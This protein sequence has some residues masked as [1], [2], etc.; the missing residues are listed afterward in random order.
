MKECPDLDALVGVEEALDWHAESAMRHIL[1]CEECLAEIRQVERLHVVLDQEIAPTPG[2][3]DRVVAALPQAVGSASQREE[4]RTRLFSAAIFVLAT[5]TAVVVLGVA[6]IASP[7]T[8]GVGPEI[9]VFASVVGFAAVK[10]IPRS[11]T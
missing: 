9:L 7:A 4:S 10:V 1:T 3:A 5:I 8:G 6:A 2:F 11:V